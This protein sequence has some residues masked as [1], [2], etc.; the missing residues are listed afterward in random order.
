VLKCESDDC[1]GPQYCVHRSIGP[2]S[3]HAV[4]DYTFYQSEF[5]LKEQSYSISDARYAVA[6]MFRDRI[7][8]RDMKRCG[9]SVAVFSLLRV[10]I[11]LLCSLYSFELLIET[12][13]ITWPDLLMLD[14]HPT[15]LQRRDV[16]P[17]ATCI[18]AGLT[19]QRIAICADD[20]QYLIHSVGLGGPDLFALGFNRVHLKALGL[21]VDDIELLS[22]P[23]GTDTFFSVFGIDSDYVNSLPST[24]PA[25]RS[26]A[27]LLLK[28]GER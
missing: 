8:P 23:T 13:D 6:K 17:V 21:R 16:F 4:Y 18:A 19:A 24:S 27:L 10:D 3:R 20:M 5:P 28:G 14:F 9:C 1:G 22:F 7:H 12:F 2:L 11:G 25:A 15:L 26:K